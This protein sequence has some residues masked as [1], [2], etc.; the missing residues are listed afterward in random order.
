MIKAAFL[1]SSIFRVSLG[2]TPYSTKQHQPANSMADIYP[3][4]AHI[5]QSNFHNIHSI[6]K[7]FIN[8]QN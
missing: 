5:H 6:S 1:L 4:I 3:S 8:E 2:S 7:N